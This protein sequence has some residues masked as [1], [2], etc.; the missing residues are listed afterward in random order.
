MLNVHG[1]W[2]WCNGKVIIIELS[3]DPREICIGSISKALMYHCDSVIFTDAEIH[4]LGS[5]RTR[6][7]GSGKEADASFSPEKPDLI[8]EQTLAKYCY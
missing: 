5:V 1:C 8:P 6:V 2:E 3:S 7:G 4:S